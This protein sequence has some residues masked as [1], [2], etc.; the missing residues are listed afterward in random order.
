VG[1]PENLQALAWIFSP[2]PNH[3]E[4]HGNGNGSK[5]F[6]L[7]RRL[8]P[9]VDARAVRRATI[10]GVDHDCLCWIVSRCPALET[11]DLR[12]YFD[13]DSRSRESVAA[14]LDATPNLRH[15]CIGSQ[16]PWPVLV[17]ELCRRASVQVLAWGCWFDEDCEEMTDTSFTKVTDEGLQEFCRACRSLSAV[18]LSQWKDGMCLPSAFEI[19]LQPGARPQSVHMSVHIFSEW[20]CEEPFMVL[21]K[22]RVT[23]RSGDIS[24]SRELHDAWVDAFLPRSH[25]TLPWRSGGCRDDAHDLDDGVRGIHGSLRSCLAMVQCR[26][27]LDVIQTTTFSITLDSWALSFKL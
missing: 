19:L 23:V 7:V 5:A 15:L 12:H 6:D 20:D 2:R 27:F 16:P 13:E 21:T 10:N 22:K 18:R 14:L 9:T 24:W 26:Y 25:G 11:L 8:L 17:S 4:V 1:G 3:L